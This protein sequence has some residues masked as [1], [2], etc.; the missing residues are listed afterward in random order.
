[1]PRGVKKEGGKGKRSAGGDSVSAFITAS[2]KFLRKLS[3]D[4]R[5]IVLRLIGREAVEQDRA[6]AAFKAPRKP[7]VKT[8]AQQ[9]QESL[10]ASA[11]TTGNTSGAAKRTQ[12]EKE[13]PQKRKTEGAEPAGGE[14]DVSRIPGVQ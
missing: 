12:K 5:Q 14:D 2:G 8:V 4:A 13:K 10:E 1:M 3:P 9:Q 6:E 11:S 7:K